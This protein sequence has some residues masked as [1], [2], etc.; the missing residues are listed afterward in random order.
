MKRAL[1]EMTW[2][3][4]AASVQNGATTVILPLGAI[5]Q[6]GPHLPL[7]TDAYRATALAE[8]LAMALPGV[9]VAPT[10]PIGCSDEHQGFDGLLGLDHGT[11][12]CVIVDCARRIVS[13]GARRLVVLSA[14]GGNSC[15]LTMAEERLAEALPA[16]SVVI[17]AS[18][19]T[20]SDAI[21]SIAAGDGVSAE[22]LGLHAGEG[23]TSEMLA[24]RPDLVH[25]EQAVL[26]CQRNADDLMPQLKRAGLQSVTPTGVLGDARGADAERG[27]R[28]LE[29]QVESYRRTLTEMTPPQ[30]RHR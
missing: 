28:Y 4:I 12:A 15:A 6:H 16:L 13:W 8:R 5:E 22:A 9:L 3:E 27:A 10:L 29:A 18:E 25:M 23:E 1:A 11:L 19:I 24:L 7:G 17:L 20:T 30:A 26:G 21:V 14:H 2:Q